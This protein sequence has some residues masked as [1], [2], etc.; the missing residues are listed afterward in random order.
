MKI[1]KHIPNFITCLNLVSGCI[2]SALA[3]EGSPKAAS[4][5]IILACIFDFLDG[6]VARLLKVSSPIGKEL[7][8]L[9][10]MVTF[11]FLPSVILFMLLKETYLSESAPLLPYASFLIAVFSALRLAKFNIDERQT[12]SFIGLPTPANALFIGS[13]PLIIEQDIF[14]FLHNPLFLLLLIFILSYLLVS[15]LELFSLKFKD[16]SWQNNKI[17]Y[18]FLALIVILGALL[19]FAAIPIIII[20]YLILSVVDKLIKK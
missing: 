17:K 14:S 20:L 18:I 4:F 1:K 5:L 7:D 15:P 8:S 6:F 16:F 9:A 3:F 19:N 10:D 2:G 13:F 11:G 12:N